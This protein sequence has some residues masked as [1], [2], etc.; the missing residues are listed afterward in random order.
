M[1]HQ[2]MEATQAAATGPMVDVIAVLAAQQDQ[3]DDL[4]ATVEAQQRTVDAHIRGRPPNRP[5]GLEPA[6][7]AGSGPGR[8]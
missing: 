6:A 4:T 5:T 1:H 8:R 3:I 2:T 7:G